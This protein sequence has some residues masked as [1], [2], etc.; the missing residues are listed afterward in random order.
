MKPFTQGSLEYTCG[1]YAIVNSIRMATLNHRRLSNAHW[2]ELYFALTEAADEKLGGT[3]SI[4]REGL[5]STELKVLLRAANRWMLA[6]T[7]V[8]VVWRKPYR[9]GETPATREYLRTLR[10]HLSAGGTAI[11]SV[12]TGE[13]HW[14]CLHGMTARS[15]TLCDSDGMTSLP[16]SCLRAE[17]VRIDPPY[18]FL[19]GVN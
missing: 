11:L 5:T 17:Q 9:V 15:F 12:S 10:R 18:T 3:G 14:T 19:I 16:I 1:L 6:A 8:K 7:K 4:I 13:E 2:I